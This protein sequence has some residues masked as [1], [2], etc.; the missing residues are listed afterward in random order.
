LKEEKR[1]DKEKKKK[2]KR[3]RRNRPSIILEGRKKKKKEMI[4]KSQI[5]RAVQKKKRKGGNF[6]SLSHVYLIHAA[7]WPRVKN[8]RRQLAACKKYTR[9]I[10]TRGHLFFANN[11]SRSH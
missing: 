2:E 9:P 1:N 7:N 3:R 8:K 6:E 11:L 10:Y 5:M 4:K